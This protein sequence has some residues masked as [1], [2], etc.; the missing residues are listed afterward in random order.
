M[1]SPCMCV[2][3]FQLATDA[4]CGNG[5]LEA[6]EECD[7]GTLEVMQKI[8]AVLLIQQ[9]LT[10]SYDRILKNQIKNSGACTNKLRTSVDLEWKEIT[11]VSWFNVSANKIRP[12]TPVQFKPDLRDSRDKR[13]ESLI[14]II[15]E[16]QQTTLTPVNMACFSL[17][18]HIIFQDC[19][20]VNDTCCNYT[21]CMLFGD[22]QCSDGACCSGCKV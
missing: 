21:S 20:R 19:E 9:K 12:G 1:S 15:A 10:Q 11:M 6:G 8:N 14:L 18:I 7:C 2:I 16:D 17:Y 3:L 4:A 5:L 13:T 22:A